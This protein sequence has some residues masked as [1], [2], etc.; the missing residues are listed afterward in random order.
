LSTKENQKKVTRLY[1]ILEAQS[2]DTRYSKWQSRKVKIAP[3]RGQFNKQVSVLKPTHTIFP[4]PVGVLGLGLGRGLL[5]NAAEVCGGH[6]IVLLTGGGGA[7]PL[8]NESAAA[9]WIRH[10]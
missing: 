1:T 4:R 3:F 10:R 5:G 2:P 7:L 6:G 9:A 8:A